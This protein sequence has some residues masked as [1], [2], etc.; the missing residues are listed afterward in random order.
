LL[1][2][3]RRKTPC[4]SNRGNDSDVERQFKLADA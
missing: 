1:V 3:S 2:R 4:E